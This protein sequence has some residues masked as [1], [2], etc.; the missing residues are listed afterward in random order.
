MLIVLNTL[1][2]GNPPPKIVTTLYSSGHT[3]CAETSIIRSLWQF[4][5]QYKTR[6][7]TRMSVGGDVLWH[8][9]V[10]NLLIFTFTMGNLTKKC[11]VS[12]RNI[13]LKITF[14]YIF[15]GGADPLFTQ[16]FGKLNPKNSIK[17]PRAEG[18]SD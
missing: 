1:K 18:L 13:D 4:L 16:P 11:L 12:A 8:D 14:C 6:L 5:S 17:Q 15:R 2:Y 3:P 7:I 10:I 9:D